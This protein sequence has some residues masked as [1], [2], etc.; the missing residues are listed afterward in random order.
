MDL[1]IGCGTC[2]ERC[3]I[4]S[5]KLVDDKANVIL[6]RCIGCGVC[7]PTCPEQAI[8]L[9]RKDQEVIP[10]NNQ[11]ELYSLIMAKKRELRKK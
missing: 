2:I 6:K 9:I 3:Q 10:P 4:H 11:E 1:C 8:Q 7:V 5:I